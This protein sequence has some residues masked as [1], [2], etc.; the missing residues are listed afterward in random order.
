MEAYTQQRQQGSIQRSKGIAMEMKKRGTERRRQHGEIQGR[1]RPSELVE[2]RHKR[3]DRTQV[4]RKEWGKN[5]S[6]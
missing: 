5:E 1:Q 6:Q 3:A 4:R 2:G